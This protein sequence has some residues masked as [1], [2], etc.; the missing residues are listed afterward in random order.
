MASGRLRVVESAGGTTRFETDDLE[1]PLFALAFDGEGRR[2][3]S[4]GADGR[5]RLYELASPRADRS[6]IDAHAG[7]VFSLDVSPDG[8]RLVST[9][10]D[11]AARVWAWGAG[12]APLSTLEGEA[13]RV[14]DARFSDDGRRIL[15]RNGDRISTFDGN[16]WARSDAELPA[17]ARSLLGFS[18]K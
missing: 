13:D 5:L 9:G 18:A 16:A 3:A 6:G 14:R 7:P 1:S 8:S 2:L 17:Y 15:K 12:H 10:A 11:G 4:G